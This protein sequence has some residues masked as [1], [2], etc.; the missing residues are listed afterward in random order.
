MTEDSSSN[1]RP[2]G[3]D[4]SSTPSRPKP[5]PVMTKYGELAT[6]RLENLNQLLELKK[7]RL[8]QLDGQVRSENLTPSINKQVRQRCDSEFTVLLEEE[9]GFRNWIWFPCMTP[10]ELTIWWKSQE[11]IAEYA[12]GL[13]SPYKLPGDLYL[14]ESEEDFNF[15]HDIFLDARFCKAWI[16]SEDDSYLITNQK[17]LIV[18]KAFPIESLDRAKMRLSRYLD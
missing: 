7:Q 1:D 13:Q 14:V 6:K 15:W 17:D 8:A 2:Q 12:D 5:P 4:N 10:P 18:D 11:R 3:S 16:N 9:C